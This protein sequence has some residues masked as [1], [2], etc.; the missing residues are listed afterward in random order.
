M[1]VGLLE[2]CGTTGRYRTWSARDV[3][4][5]S[6]KVLK[7]WKLKLDSE[8]LRIDPSTLIHGDRIV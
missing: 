7:P 3:C 6:F 1:S 4:P 5:Q 2:L 8:H